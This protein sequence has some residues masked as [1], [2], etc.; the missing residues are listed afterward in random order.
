VGSLNTFDYTLLQYLGIAYISA[1]RQKGLA[2]NL[3]E[4]GRY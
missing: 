3:T 2:N 1:S 4:S